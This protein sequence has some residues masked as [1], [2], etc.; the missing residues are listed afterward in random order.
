MG[1]PTAAQ[2][3]PESI[4]L[5]DVYQGNG[6]SPQIDLRLQLR[7]E[8]EALMAGWKR[9]SN[10]GRKLIERP[11][12]QEPPGLALLT[13]APLL[14]EERNPRCATLREYSTHPCGINRP[15]T[16]AALAAHDHPMD[17]AEVDPAD[18]FEERFDGKETELRRRTAQHVDPRNAILAI[19][20]AHAP[21]DVR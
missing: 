12:V 20:D 19:L 13:S 1:F 21:P 14:E 5:R 18:V 3:Y 2:Q 15:G 4:P 8:G 9:F 6:V 11:I 7:R 10:N 17:L 16:V